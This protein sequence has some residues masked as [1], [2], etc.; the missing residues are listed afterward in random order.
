MPTELAD[1]QAVGDVRAA[2][3]VDR[4]TE[5]LAKN[6][7]EIK[8]P[9]AVKQFKYGQSNPTYFLTDASGKRFVLRK[10]PAGTLLS[11][12]AH[13]VE[14]EYQMLRALQTHND[15]TQDAARR[16]PIP[17]P[18]VLCEDESVIGTPFYVMEFLEGRIFSDQRMLSLPPEERR[19]CWLS[20][21]QSLALL[22]SL[23][24]DEIGLE[25][26]ASRKPYFPRQIRSLSEV[27]IAQSKA[28]DVETKKPTGEIPH[29][30]DLIAWYTAN[31]PDEAKIGRRIVHGDYKIDNLIYHPT[32]PRVIGILDWELCSLGSPLPD[33]ANLTLSFF[34]SDSMFHGVARESSLLV[35][36]RDKPRSEVPVAYDELEREYCR[37]MHL[38]YPIRE[39]TFA[40]SWMVFRLSVITQGIAARYARRQASSERASTY[41]IMFP[42]LGR[43]AKQLI[44]EGASDKPKPKL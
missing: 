8:T 37:I 34:I 18:Y 30:R 40:S 26:F 41:A 33:V 3:P 27:S 25:S 13:Q 16:V 44:D 21:I 35:T 24:P 29:F 7:R 23:N 22:H 17:R 15:A 42:T 14:R 39:M 28:V 6:V 20:A 4:L 5:Y 9:V 32:E 38:D 1:G 2:I 19:L 31:I 11:K 43:I 12:T 36:F 10:K